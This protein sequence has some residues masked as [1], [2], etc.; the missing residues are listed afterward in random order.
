MTNFS[1]SIVQTS[2]NEKDTYYIF[3]HVE[4]TIYYHSEV[5]NAG[6]RLVAAKLEPK[7]YAKCKR[8]VQY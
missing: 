7:R 3:N 4:I 5:E 8:C 2:F 6:S 1:H